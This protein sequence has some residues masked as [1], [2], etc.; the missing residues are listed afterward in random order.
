M[1]EII[2]IDEK[3]PLD[4]Q[5]DKALKLLKEGEVVAIPTDT[6]YGLAALISDEKVVKKV[7]GV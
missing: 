3:R 4:D 5:L 2:L 7:Y 1:A 6:L